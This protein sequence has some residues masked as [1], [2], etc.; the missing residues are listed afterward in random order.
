L[1][2]RAPPLPPLFPY[3]TLFRSL[4]GQAEA[5]E[6]AHGP[7]LAAVA[8]GVHAAGVWILARIAQVALVVEVGQVIGGGERLDL[9][10]GGRQEVLGPLLRASEVGFPALS[11]RL[12]RGAS[13]ASLNGSNPALARHMLS[14]FARVS[15]AE[16][17]GR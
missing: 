13:D 10:A 9:L 5:G 6:H 15:L 1:I 4:L 16:D 8:A 3:T 11:A 2:T 7:E 12:F 14:D 17:A